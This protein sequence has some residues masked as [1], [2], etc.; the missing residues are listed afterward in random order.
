MSIPVE[1]VGVVSTTLTSR[2]RRSK[3]LT[4]SVTS[5]SGDELVKTRTFAVGIFSAMAVARDSTKRLEFEVTKQRLWAAMLD[6]S[7]AT[8]CDWLS[9]NLIELGSGTGR[10]RSTLVAASGFAF[11]RNRYVAQ[12]KSASR[13]TTRAARETR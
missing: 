5:R 2:I 1:S 10:F 6:N 13:A 7:S 11:V 3:F 9:N 8:R 4:K 12:P